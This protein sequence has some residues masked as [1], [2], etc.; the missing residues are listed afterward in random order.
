MSPQISR[1]GN[2]GFVLHKLTLD[3][4]QG[5]FSA[6]YD[7]DG[8]LTDAEQFDRMNRARPVRR[9]GPTWSALE[10]YGRIYVEKEVWDQMPH[11]VRENPARMKAS[12]ASFDD[13]NRFY[14]S[15]RYPHK[16]GH[17][18]HV[19]RVVDDGM[20]AAAIR[21]HQTDIVTYREDGSIKLDS[22]K[23]RTA[24]TKSHMNSV[25]PPGV[26]VYQKKGE[27]FV[28]LGGGREVEFFD[29]MILGNPDVAHVP[30]AHHLPNPGKF[31]VFAWHPDSRYRM[32]E[33][34]KTYARQADAQRYADQLNARQDTTQYR[35]G[36][37]GSGGYVVRDLAYVHNPSPHFAYFSK[38]GAR[39]VRLSREGVELFNARWP[40]STLRDR[41]YWFEFDHTG[42][43][44]DTD[45]PE[46]DDGP[47]AAALSE[48]ARTWLYE[49][50]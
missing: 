39:K 23:Y 25:L 26:S 15:S 22:G 1:F 3:G 43:L 14:E 4:T 18:T 50:G 17:N 47:A 36:D 40:G 19:F 13:A 34:L 35:H 27:W 33:A 10:R 5:R 45:V 9:D 32:S 49:Q 11:N 16:L 2:G 48:D 37:V 29:G 30:S 31:G 44:V 46:H 41:S 28:T 20:R 8:T 24:T 7:R 42:D 38:V 6:W 12:I 21:Y